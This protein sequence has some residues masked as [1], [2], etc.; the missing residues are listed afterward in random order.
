MKPLMSPSAIRLNAVRSDLARLEGSR[1]SER[2]DII[3]SERPHVR[4]PA[5]LGWVGRLRGRPT[6]S[7]VIDQHPGIAGQRGWSK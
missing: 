1:S 5:G 7:R 6:A 2:V 3:R 4:G